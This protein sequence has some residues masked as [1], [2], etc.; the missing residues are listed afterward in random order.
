MAILKAL[1][2][3]KNSN[4]GKKKTVLVYT[5]SRITLQLLQNQKEHIN[6][7]EQ[8][9]T[10]FIEM[11]KQDWKVEFSWTKE[12]AGNRGNEL[13]DHMAK[14]AASSNT[15]DECYNKIPKSEVMGELN[16]LGA[17]SGKVNGKE[18]PKVH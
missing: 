13:A 4:A 7:I 9:R 5:D 16:E 15:I 2:F 3:I 14:E 11:E 17:K 18:L 10:K 12:H 6:L 8:I 1:E